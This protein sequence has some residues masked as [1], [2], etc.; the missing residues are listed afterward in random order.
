MGRKLAKS[1]GFVFPGVVALALA[2]APGVPRIGVAAAET[3]PARYSDRMRAFPLL[4]SLCPP[5]IS[6]HQLRW[7][8]VRTSRIRFD[9]CGLDWKR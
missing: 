8:R 9:S 3:M 2:V 5:V 6:I 1:L 4:V 7:Y